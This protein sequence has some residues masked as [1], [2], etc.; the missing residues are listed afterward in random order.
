M[1]DDQ[2]REETSAQTERTRSVL[3]RWL[4][5]FWLVEITRLLAAGASYFP[6]LN[7]PARWG[8]QVLVVAGVICLYCLGPA[9][10]RYR[11]AAF[12]RGVVVLILPVVGLL[13]TGR[14]LAILL[15]AL[16]MICSLAATCS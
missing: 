8:I 7:G 10:L 11:W 1:L 4:K 6:P 16:E 12:L 14:T 5:A 3:C 13:I 9:C 2:M 15:T